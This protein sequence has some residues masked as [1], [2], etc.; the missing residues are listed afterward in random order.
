MPIPRN[1]IENRSGRRVL[2]VAL[3]CLSL[4][5]CGGGDTPASGTNAQGTI[6]VGQTPA[7]SISLLAGAINEPGYKDGSAFEARFNRPAW[8]IYNS[9]GV[10]YLALHSGPS[11]IVSD[12]NGG[13]YVLDAPQ[14]AISLYEANPAYDKGMP[15]RRISPSGVVT[16][17]VTIQGPNQAAHLAVDPDGALYF[18]SG[19]KIH[20]VAQQGGESVFLTGSSRY[21]SSADIPASSTVDHFYKPGPIVFDRDGNLYVSDGLYI[22]KISRDSTS[23]LFAT[24]PA[25]SGATTSMN[26]DVNGNLYLTQAEVRWQPGHTLIGHDRGVIIKIK[27]DGEVVVIAGTLEGV[28]HADGA[29]KDARFSNP[30]GLAID[31]AGNLYV[32]DS[33]NQV[34]RKIDVNGMVTT[35]A[36]TPGVNVPGTGSLPGTLSEP[37]GLA[38]IGPK[39]L[40][41]T[42]G[43]AVAKIVLP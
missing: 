13:L 29:G 19:N 17:F 32:A 2:A 40:A 14:Q 6:A 42:T 12:G 31:E 21:Q 20:K 36:G 41:V 9:E 33:M 3:L 37:Y 23:R 26:V 18:T 39:T 11:R 5:A 8:A 16:T 35:V 10:A 25:G 30:T 27:P 22:R 38:F 15:I 24:L 34:I 28:G 4:A 7:P 1:D 43:T